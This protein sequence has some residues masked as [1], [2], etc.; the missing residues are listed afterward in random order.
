MEYGFAILLLIF[1]GMI[2]LYAAMLAVVK[3]KKYLPFRIRH[4]IPTD[5]EKEYI[6][7]LAKVL[8]LVAFSPI[9]GG[10]LGFVLPPNAAVIIFIVLLVLFII[11][12]AKVT[13]ING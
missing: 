3:S 11:V 12:G 5:N 4:T 13:K 7:K 8:A 1:G 6:V 10:A 2:L 9:I